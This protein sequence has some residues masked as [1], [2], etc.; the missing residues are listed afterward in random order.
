MLT[1]ST[2]ANAIEKIEVGINA[3]DLDASYGDLHD[4]LWERRAALAIAATFL[5][6]N[7]PEEAIFLHGLLQEYVEFVDIDPACES[8]RDDAIDAIMRMNETLRDYALNVAA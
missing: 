6:P 1:L 3:T 8:D 7:T 5:I 2:L 4:R